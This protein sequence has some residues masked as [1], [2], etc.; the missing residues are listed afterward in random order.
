M[1]LVLTTFV[2][3]FFDGSFGLCFVLFLRWTTVVRDVDRSKAEAKRAVPRA[4]TLVGPSANASASSRSQ[5]GLGSLCLQYRRGSLSLSL[6]PICTSKN[7]AFT[8]QLLALEASV[9][10]H[11]TADGVGNSTQ[12]NRRT[13]KRRLF[14]VN[15]RSRSRIL[16]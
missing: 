10:C 8:P 12:K 15:F 16:N 14:L 1:T 13:D 11:K 9:E 6:S 2:S 4:R 5:E 3:F 7:N